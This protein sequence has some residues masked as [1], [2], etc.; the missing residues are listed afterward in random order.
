[1]YYVLKIKLANVHNFSIIPNFNFWKL[2]LVIIIL[3]FVTAVHTKNAQSKQGDNITLTN[4]E[5][6]ALLLCDLCGKRI[7]NN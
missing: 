2:F 4:F 6:F 3:S 5:T 1:L 7:K